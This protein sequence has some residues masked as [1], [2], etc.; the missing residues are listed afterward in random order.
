MKEKK[1][2]KNLVTEIKR[3][4]A[5]MNFATQVAAAKKSKKKDI[6]NKK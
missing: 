1:G 3:L 4:I 5:H 2:D 6:N